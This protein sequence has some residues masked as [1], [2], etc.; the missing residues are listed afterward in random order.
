MFHTYFLG[1]A[2]G[3][4]FDVPVD[5]YDTALWAPLGRYLH[6]L[7]VEVRTS[8]AVTALSLPEPAIRSSSRRR[9]VELTLDTGE[10][11]TADGVVLATD[12]ATTRRLIARGDR[13]HRRGL[14]RPGGGDPQRAAVRGLA[15]VAGPS[16]E[17]RSGARS[18]A[19]AASGRWTTSP[20]WSASRPAPRRGRGPR[21]ARSWSCTRTPCRSR[22]T[23]RR[24]ARGCAPSSGRS[25]PRRVAADIVAEEWLVRADCPLVGHRAVAAAARRGDAAPA[26]GAGRR[27]RPLRLPGG[28][29][30]AGRHDRLPGRQRPAGALGRR[31][32]TTSGPCRWRAATPPP[33]GSPAAPAPNPLTRHIFGA[34]DGVSQQ[35]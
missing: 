14:A 17:R 19:P 23:R 20:C 25:I 5:D 18:W 1:S 33:A 22:W 9:A 26:V 28:A 15:A 27:R 2:E 12:P 29:D 24:C 3:L 6:G 30:G 7:G 16:G 13:H 31:P 11:L 10:T 8:T 35:M 21:A 34:F 4:L 32:A